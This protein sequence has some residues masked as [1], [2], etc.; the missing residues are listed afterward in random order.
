MKC[1]GGRECVLLGLL[2]SRSSVPR[3]FYRSVAREYQ[4][5]ESEWQR[6]ADPH[7]MLKA[8]RDSSTESVHRSIACEFA[9]LVWNDLPGVA[10]DALTTAE[11][12]ANGTG[13]VE[14][15]RTVQTELQ[16]LLPDDYS[17]APVSAV[18]WALQESTSSY[19]AWYSAA[20][21]GLNI[22]SLGTAQ[23]NALCTIIRQYATCPSSSC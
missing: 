18:I 19:P 3:D 22:I 15:C 17:S 5:T 2:A 1:T 6:S 11:A 21:A 20:L 14:R 10:R 9:R 23:P 8:I 7:A 4:L 13:D 12:L 16:A